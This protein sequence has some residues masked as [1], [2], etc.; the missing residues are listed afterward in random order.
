MSDGKDK[1]AQCPF[2]RGVGRR[3]IGCEGVTDESTATLLFESEELR[4]AFKAEKCD[5]WFKYCP[6]YCGLMTKYGDELV[7]K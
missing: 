7:R 4:D 1:N 6:Y 5:A 2:Y 3:S